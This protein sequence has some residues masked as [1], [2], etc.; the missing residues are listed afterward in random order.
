[1]IGDTVRIPLIQV[2]S[3]VPIIREPDVSISRANPKRQS[4]SF[5][6]V[7]RDLKKEVELSENWA[8]RGPENPTIPDSGINDDLVAT[9]IVWVAVKS[10]ENSHWVYKA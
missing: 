1:M 5:P 6:W 3:R 4:L 10:L 7:Q 8:N 9:P 2:V